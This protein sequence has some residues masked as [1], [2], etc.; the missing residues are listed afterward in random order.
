VRDVWAKQNQIARAVVSD[1]IPYQSLASAFN[2]ERKL[3]FRM[4]MPV[5]REAGI[6]ADIGT[7][8][9]RS[10]H[11]LL[12]VRLHVRSVRLDWQI[13]KD[14]RRMGVN[15]VP[16]VV[17]LREDTDETHDYSCERSRARPGTRPKRKPFRSWTHVTR[18][19]LAA[20]VRNVPRLL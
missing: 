20:F 10:G 17:N 2:D 4:V 8:G 16:I 11:E 15:S 12:K 3:I 14:L 7:K 19:K 18:Q 13:F 9:R 6:V 5:E 1:A